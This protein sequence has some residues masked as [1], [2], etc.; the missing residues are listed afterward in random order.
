MMSMA[1]PFIHS[2]IL[3]LFN[4]C[5]LNVRYYLDIRVTELNEISKVLAFMDFT[6]QRREFDVKQGSKSGR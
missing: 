4:A 2:F 3:N 5:P 6:F 1:H